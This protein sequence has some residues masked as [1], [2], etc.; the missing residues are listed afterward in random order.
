MKIYMTIWHS[1]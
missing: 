1:G